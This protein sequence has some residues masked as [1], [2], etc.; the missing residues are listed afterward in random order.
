MKT[1]LLPLL[2][3]VALAL[4]LTSCVPL[5]D[6]YFAG[7]GGGGYS[8]GSTGYARSYSDYGGSSSQRY[9]NDDGHNHGGSYGSHQ[10]HGYVS[11]G[12]GYSSSSR[13]CSVCRRNPCVCRQHN[14]NHGS[15]GNHSSSHSNNSSDE[16]KYEYRGSVGRGDSKPEGNHTRDWYK[17]R[18]YPLK[19]LRPAN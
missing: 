8:S 18:G 10:P 16:K 19:N 13:L 7:G 11:S 17:E 9:Y 4:C 5:D 15:S 12:Y 1:L 3:V 14:D 6:P 2:T